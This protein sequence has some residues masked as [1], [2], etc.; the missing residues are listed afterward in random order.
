MIT[1]SRGITDRQFVYKCLDAVYEKRKFNLLLHGG[2]KGVDSIAGEWASKKGISVLY[3]KPD[4]ERYGRSAGL[5]R[6]TI[7]SKECDFG[8]A[9]WDG[10]S[11]GTKDAIKKLRLKNKLYKVF[12]TEQMVSLS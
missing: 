12:K 9:L 1:G 11:K 6:N 3:F 10:K 2:A 4:W 5:R 8:V 7:M